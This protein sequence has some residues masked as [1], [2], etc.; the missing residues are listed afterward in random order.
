MIGHGWVDLKAAVAT[1]RSREEKTT[2]LVV[3][4]GDEIVSRR[5]DPN[6]G[7]MH[8]G[9]AVVQGWWSRLHRWPISLCFGF[10][11][12]DSWV[13]CGW[14]CGGVIWLDSGVG[15]RSL[16]LSLLALSLSLSLSL[17]FFWCESLKNG[18]WR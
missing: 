16:W 2:R 12:R 11:W 14:D 6:C 9:K 3:G 10:A 4:G 5:S 7:C 15:G 1:T 13:M 17:S 18:V 8:D